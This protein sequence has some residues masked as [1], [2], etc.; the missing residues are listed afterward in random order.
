MSTAQ[1]SS[2]TDFPILAAFSSDRAQEQSTED[3]NDI[4]TGHHHPSSVGN[5]MPAYA[6]EFFPMYDGDS[7]V[8]QSDICRESRVEC[9]LELTLNLSLLRFF[10]ELWFSSA[11]VAYNGIIALFLSKFAALRCLL[12]LRRWRILS[13]YFGGRYT[14]LANR[15][16]LSFAFESMCVVKAFNYS[17]S[18]TYG[19]L[20]IGA[21]CF[22]VMQAW[23]RVMFMV[24]VPI[25]WKARISQRTLKQAFHLWKRARG[26]LRG[27]QHQL[28]WRLSLRHHRKTLLVMTFK[29]FRDYICIAR[30]AAIKIQATFRCFILRRNS[31]AM[32]LDA[33]TSVPSVA[34]S[35]PTFSDTDT[36]EIIR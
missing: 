8:H 9:K 14:R 25:V 33:V 30:A 34:V 20:G 7:S 32:P 5:A 28:H 31:V 11:D 12:I 16:L 10:F 13:V 18:Y 35:S 19:G 29:Y 21:R 36:V 6:P 23:I 27:L 1:P 3:V 26:T 24:E 15:A 22:N 4:S 17:T 2:S